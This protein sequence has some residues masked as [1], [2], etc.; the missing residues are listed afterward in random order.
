MATLPTGTSGTRS[1]KGT[2]SIGKE[3][4]NRRLEDYGSLKPLLEKV[5]NRD[6]KV[7]IL[8]CGNAGK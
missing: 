5:M 2:C 8:G 6:S 7:L 3:S 1:R 4:S